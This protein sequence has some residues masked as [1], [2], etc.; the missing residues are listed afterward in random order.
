M[1]RLRSGTRQGIVVGAGVA[2]IAGVHARLRPRGSP[3]SG[4]TSAPLI[5]AAHT[6]RVSRSPA[7]LLALAGRG[8]WVCSSSSNRRPLPPLPHHVTSSGLPFFNGRG[9]LTPTCICNFFL[10]NIDSRLM[11][12]LSKL[13][14]LTPASKVDSMCSSLFVLLYA[15]ITLDL[16]HLSLSRCCIH[17]KCIATTHKVPVLV[18]S[19]NLSEISTHA[20]I[21]CQCSIISFLCGSCTMAE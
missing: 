21:L 12:D 10:G 4:A 9:R 17:G 1:R 11:Y 2:P 13:Y 18:S 20:A 16:Q 6:P 3:S 8:A 19:M 15:F 7:C 5:A 14:C